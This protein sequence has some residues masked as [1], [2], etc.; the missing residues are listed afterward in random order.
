MAPVVDGIALARDGPAL[1]DMLI[2]GGPGSQYGILVVPP[3]GW[4]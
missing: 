2:F 3:A 1:G 4:S